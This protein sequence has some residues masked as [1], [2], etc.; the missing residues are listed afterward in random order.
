MSR[1]LTTPVKGTRIVERRTLELGLGGA[2]SDRLFY[3]VDDRGRVVNGRQH[4][5]LAE[6]G[7]RFDPA[8]GR[9]T[10]TFPGG[11]TVA[12]PVRVGGEQVRTDFFSHDTMGEVVDGPFAAALT[13]HAGRDLRL[14]RVVEPGAGS[15]RHPL[16]IVSSASLDFLRTRSE[17]ALEV[18]ARRF[19]MLI[20]VSGCRPHEEDTWTG[21]VLRGGTVA[22]RVLETVP[23][24]SVVRQDP[25]TGL[26]S[27]DALRALLE[28]RKSRDS[29]YRWPVVQPPEARQI[30]FGVYAVVEQPG[31]LSLGDEIE[32][33]AADL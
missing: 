8:D 20:E 28:Y 17:D 1:L 24:C 26:R 21:G 7:S 31:T 15:D 30:M 32:F 23:R 13:R 2:A 14:V 5:P 3:L 19:R 33:A 18:D 11:E 29:R 27:F 12:A 6:I 16:S 9:L 4:G 25:A 10:L 22:L